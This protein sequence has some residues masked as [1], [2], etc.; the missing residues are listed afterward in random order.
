MADIEVEKALSE[1]RERVRAA[2]AAQEAPHAGGL[3]PRRTPE[4][5]PAAGDISVATA[6]TAGL[7]PLAEPAAAA[8]ARLHANLATLDRTWNKLPPLMSNRRGWLA[9]LELWIKRQIKRATHWYTWEQVNFNAAVHHALRD[10]SAALSAYEGQLASY[11][12]QVTALRA[13]LAALE[14]VRAEIRAEM[15]PRFVTLEDKINSRATQ[16]QDLAMTLGERLRHEQRERI[17]HVLDEQRVCFRQLAIETSETAV[18]FDRGRRDTAAQLE[19]LARGLAELHGAVA[20]LLRTEEQPGA[21]PRHG[22]A[23]R[24]HGG[25]DERA[26]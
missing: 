22:D 24:T 10:V 3:A 18:F 25:G 13:Q 6:A 23:T 8:R 11:E 7:A 4:D 20:A 19:E 16:L 1:I 2:A 14:P 12:Q 15:D 21:H 17:E 26:P 5:A 9:A